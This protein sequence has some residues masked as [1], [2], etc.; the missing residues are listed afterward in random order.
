M[1]NTNGDWLYYIVILVVAIITWV[2]S[3]NKKKQ[4]A[5]TSSPQE[6][7]PVSPPEVAS[8]RRRTPPPAPKQLRWQSRF[9]SQATNEGE[10]VLTAEQLVSTDET[11]EVWAD[12]LDLSD[13]NAIR[14][15]VIYAEILNRKY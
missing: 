15:A 1:D 11:E 13:T 5:Q 3:L 6:M 10:R 14:K 4:Q 9:P 8:S 12:E 7:P 2:S